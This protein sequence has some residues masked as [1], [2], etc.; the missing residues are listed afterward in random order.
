MRIHGANRSCTAKTVCLAVLFWSIFLF[1]GTSGHT[2]P[3]DAPASFAN[4]VQSVENSVVNISTTEKTKQAPLQQFGGPNSPFGQFFGEQF[5]NFFGN[6]P[7]GEVE[8]H[9]LGSGFLISDNGLILTNNHVISKADEIKVKTFDGKI[10]DAKVVGRD[11]KTDLALIRITGP[12]GTLP[13]PAVL[14]NSDAIRVGDWVIAVGNP[15]GLGNTV[16]AGIISAKGRIIGEGPY[17]D[18]LQ[19]DAAINPGNSGGPLFNMQG[20]VVGINTAIV[21]QGQGI[22]FAIP[23]NIAKSILGQLKTGKVIRGWLGIMIQNITPELAKSFGISATKGVIVADVVQQGP[24]AKAGVKRGDVIKTLDGKTVENASELSRRVAAIKPGTAVSLGIIRDGKHI[25]VNVKLGTLPAKLPKAGTLV[26]GT[27]T[28]WGITVQNLTPELAQTFG[29]SAG[30]TGV[31]IT[32]V[33]PG[34]AAADAM[35]R[36]GDVIKR[37]NRQKVENIQDWKKAIAKM[38]KGEPLLLLVERGGTTFYVA[39]KPAD[40]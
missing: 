11:P 17:D 19:T 27:E 21:A 10:Y 2:A 25:T 33:K 31:I 30:E 35:L 24:A 12:K 34:S 26:P 40:K 28:A 1:S 32:K 14:G 15:F 38:K 3:F 18:F 22:G 13:N 29:L 39:I 37:V 8:T 4:L 9:A 23:I 6:I 36:T 7:R 20:Q 5:K 16:T